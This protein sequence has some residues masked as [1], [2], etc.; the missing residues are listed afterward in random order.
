MKQRLLEGLASVNSKPQ[1]HA[2]S[3]AIAE[4]VSAIACEGKAWDEVLGQI[5]TLLRDA[6]ENRR[7][8]AAFLLCKIAEYAGE[9]VL[10]PHA[11]ELWPTIHNLLSD[12]CVQVTSRGIQ[13]ICYLILSMDGTS[14]RQCSQLIQPIL[15]VWYRDVSLV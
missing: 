3:H 4:L 8:I 10:V 1:G 7:E 15:E 13:A 11:K 2:L 12:S 9:E 14:Q 5:T 6:Q